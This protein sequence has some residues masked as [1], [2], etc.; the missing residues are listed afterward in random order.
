LEDMLSCP[1]AQTA[2]QSARR[3]EPACGRGARTHHDNG[4]RIGDN[5]AGETHDR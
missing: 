4:L 1:T 2:A 5:A 3:A